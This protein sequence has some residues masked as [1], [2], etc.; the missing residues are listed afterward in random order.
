MQLEGVN[1][2]I[3]ADALAIAAEIIEAMAVGRMPSGVPYCSQGIV[4]VV[5]RVAGII[6]Y[7]QGG[8]KEKYNPSSFVDIDEAYRGEFHALIDAAMDAI[9]AERAMPHIRDEI[10]RINKKRG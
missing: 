2:L 9:A 7:A 10:D 1:K 3:H 8:Y 4:M 6:A 5:A